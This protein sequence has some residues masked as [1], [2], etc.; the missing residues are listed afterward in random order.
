M[1][2]IDAPSKRDFIIEIKGGIRVFRGYYK[3]NKA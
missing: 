3:N 2:E 1:W